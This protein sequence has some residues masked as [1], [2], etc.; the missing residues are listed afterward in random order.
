IRC[1]HGAQDQKAM[2]SSWF[3]FI[4]H[5]TASYQGS[6]LRRK[7]KRAVLPRPIQRFHAEPILGEKEF[8][9]VHRTEVKDGKRE[10]PPE[11]LD[12]LFSPLLVAMEDRLCISFRMESVSSPLKLGA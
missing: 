3:W 7:L 10:H 5:Q 11:M 2:E 4:G 1:R 6:N 8:W 9:V 12:Y